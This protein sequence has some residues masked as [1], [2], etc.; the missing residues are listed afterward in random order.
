M[1]MPLATLFIVFVLLNCV[2]AIPSTYNPLEARAVPP[3]WQA[4]GCYTDNAQARTLAATSTTQNTLTTESCVAFC[5]AGGYTYAGTEFGKQCYC[6]YAIQNTG[7]RT[8]NQNECNSACAGNAADKSYYS[9]G[10]AGTFAFQGYYTDSTAARTLDASAAVPGGVTAASC[11]N[12]CRAQGYIYAG[13]EFG[14]QC[15]CGNDINTSGALASATDCRQA[16]AADIS[17]FCGGKNRLQL[18]LN[19]QPCI[20]NIGT[21]GPFA[22][23]AVPAS[24]PTRQLGIG[25]LTGGGILGTL[26]GGTGY[27]SVF[28]AGTFTANQFRL[29]D[30]SLSATVNALVVPVG[31]A[32]SSSVGDGDTPAFDVTPVLPISPPIVAGSFDQ[33]CVTTVAGGNDL[34]GVYDR[35]DLWSLCT[36]TTAANR[37]DVVYD[38]KPSDTTITGCTSV[39][40]TLPQ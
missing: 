16:C 27:L 24:G 12:T 6:D 9:A 34:L 29:V 7:T 38:A 37:V 19:T 2:G 21:I 17:Q 40:I 39:R 25:G 18:Y 11:A 3:G 5:Q 23:T 20:K 22:L 26:L 14:N 4:L 30:G 10:H 13:V 35:P 28:V 15:F 8:A 1:A 33:Y 31:S 32:T 36:N